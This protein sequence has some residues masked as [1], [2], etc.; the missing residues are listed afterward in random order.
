MTDPTSLRK[1]ADTFP[2]QASRPVTAGESDR[3]TSAGKT[4]RP[5]SRPAGL[6]IGFLMLSLTVSAL[7][8]CGDGDREEA[9]DH[10]Q[11]VEIILAHAM[12]LTHPVSVAMDRMADNVE[13]YSGG[14]VTMTIYPAGQLGGERKL[15]ELIQIGAIGMTKV[16]T[17]TLENI[18]PA[19]RVFSMPYLF[20]DKEHSFNV[21]FGPLGEE[22]LL[23]GERYRLRG[24]GYYDA[25]SRSLYTTN[26]PV[27]TP[28]DL[29]G[30]KIRVMESVIAMQLMRT[31]GGSPTPLSYGE[32]YT[33]FQGGIVD[34]AEN[35][36]PSFYT[37][38]HYEVC[39]YYTLNEHTTIPD[40]LVM[41][42][43]LWER[44]TDQQQEWLQ[45]AVDESI[46][47]Q[48]ELWRESEEESMQA[49]RDA[50]VEIIHP[51]KEPFRQAV[52]PL[53]DDVRRRNPE[54]Y[55][56]VERIRNVE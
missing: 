51:D 5:G 24:V 35:N 19:M 10:D 38:R 41:D 25:G 56:W 7:T 9:A 30:Q 14:Q 20:R 45:R 37:S 36:P 4:G 1:A 49:F 23:E 32:L 31:L 50:G 18:V 54:L 8:S 29:Q 44:L 52:Q 16:S 46:E 43:R 48:I 47:F 42:S 55:N 13:E 12:H 21:L 2:D 27:H 26:R 6:L 34:G 22:L 40:I 39:N 17:A 3:K 15:L 11:P 33:A 28:E 53:Y